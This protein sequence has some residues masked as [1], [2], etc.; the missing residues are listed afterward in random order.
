MAVATLPFGLSAAGQLVSLAMR[1][2]CSCVSDS[3]MADANGTF[4]ASSS[5]VVAL[6]TNN[7]GADSELTQRSLPEISM[8]V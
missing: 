2:M 6:L 7:V 1:S 8:N 4:V 3:T 5:D